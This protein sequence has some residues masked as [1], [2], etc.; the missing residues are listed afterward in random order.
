MGNFTG[1][2]VA[3]NIFREGKTQWVFLIGTKF[4][5]ITEQPL[6]LYFYYPGMTVGDLNDKSLGCQEY[7]TMAIYHGKKTNWNKLNKTLKV[8]HMATIAH[9]LANWQPLKQVMAACSC[10]VLAN[11]G[12]LIQAYK[13]KHAKG[14]GINC[15]ALSSK[16]S[17]KTICHYFRA[18]NCGRICDLFFF[19]ATDRKSVV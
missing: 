7:C 17:N 8:D 3:N 13:D 19:F 2:D 9:S 5:Y 16:I 1:L 10:T 4:D 12:T 11:I 14:K 15:N 6:V 18:R